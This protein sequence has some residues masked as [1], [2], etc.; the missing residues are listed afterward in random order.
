MKCCAGKSWLLIPSLEQ[1]RASTA[2]KGKKWEEVPENL[3]QFQSLQ[4]GSLRSLQPS[5]KRTEKQIKL[6]VE[7][8][9][10]SAAMKL[11]YTSLVCCFCILVF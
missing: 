3:N 6:Q 2:A 5:C 1:K 9:P 11:H 8:K 4:N 10:T 7:L